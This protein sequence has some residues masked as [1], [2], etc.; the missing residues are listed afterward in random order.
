MAS[1]FI[2]WS[3][4]RLGTASVEAQYVVAHPQASHNLGFFA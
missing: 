4:L 2:G 3:R 1:A